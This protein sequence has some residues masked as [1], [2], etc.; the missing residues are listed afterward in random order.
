MSEVVTFL[1][2][3]FDH[4]VSAGALDHLLFL[5]VL[6]APFRAR[7]WRTLLVVASAFT[8]GHSVTLALAVTDLVHAPTRLIEFLIPL[9]IVGAGLQNLRGR[10]T[11]V[12]A[13]TRPVFAAGFGLIHGA[14]F[15]TV[16][17]EL[18][19]ESPAVPLLGFNLGIELGQVV[20]L[21]LALLA[22][23]GVDRL[24]A[25]LGP[26]KRRPRG[27]VL[28]SLVACAWAA[29]MAVQRVPW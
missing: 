23:G 24:L 26:I 7:D 11:E 9:T 15:A 12:K 25:G 4:I 10:E 19:I 28:A 6:V 14:G 17:R 13:W 29:I 3:G 22:T 27:A 8:V 1:R 20:V 18:M 16:L 21:S 2:L 5:L